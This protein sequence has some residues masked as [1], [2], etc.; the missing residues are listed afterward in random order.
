MARYEEKFIVVNTKHLTPNQRL[1]LSSLLIEFGVPDNKY[2]A[3]NQDEPYA[4]KIKQ[5][6]LEGEYEKELAAIPNKEQE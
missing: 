6:I 5:T 3:C 4:E 2:Y 1:I